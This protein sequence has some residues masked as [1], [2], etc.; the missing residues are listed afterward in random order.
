MAEAMIQGTLDKSSFAERN[1]TDPR[2]NAIADKVE[3]VI[4]PHATDRRQLGGTVEIEL[5]DG[6]KV[7]FTVPHMRGMPQNPMSES[8]LLNKFRVNAD[9]LMS[10]AAID[11]LTGLMLSLD[12]QA[13][14][15]MLLKAI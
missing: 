10:A 8:D 15:S 13:D 3:I 14:I 11:R 7:S 9:G 6:R 4:D 1:L 12:E 2:F 5:G